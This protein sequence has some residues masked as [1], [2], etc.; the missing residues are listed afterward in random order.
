MMRHV[1]GFISARAYSP[2][3]A[4]QRRSILRHFCEQVTDPTPDEVLAWWATISHLAP[5]SRAAHLS[6]VRAF[7][8]HLRTLGLIDH[9]P[10][11]TIRRPTNPPRPPVT[12]SAPQIVALL[13]TVTTLRERAVAALM[14]GCGLRACDVAA[15]DV[16]NVDLTDR[17]LRVRG[18]GNKYRLVPMPL[19]TVECVADYLA[20]FPAS[21]GPLMR[22]CSGARMSPDYLRYRMTRALYRAGVKQCA[23]DGRSPHVL[24]RTC[25]T[26]L[27]ESG[28]S[29]REVQSVLGHSSI[30]STERY[31]A[32]PDAKRLVDV[33]ER[34][35][36][37]TV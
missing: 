36:M 8:E 25:A 18:K 16:D 23:H 11:L 17:I 28:A 21:S 5:A 2:D 30:S 9:D 20:R 10:T 22:N 31:L 3:S 6:C 29:I 33:V 12:L 4:R 27:L 34:G 35:P 15:L 19:A 7:L 24:R 13:V 26:A 37:S 1:P 14:L 32:L